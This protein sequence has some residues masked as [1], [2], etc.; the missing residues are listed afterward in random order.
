MPPGV[1]VCPGAGT[2]A[3]FA[4]SRVVEK[5]DSQCGSSIGIY[6]IVKGVLPI[7]TLSELLQATGQQITVCPE[8]WC[9]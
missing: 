6:L 3:A 5:E 7:R 9:R 8:R 2:L 1:M 4:L